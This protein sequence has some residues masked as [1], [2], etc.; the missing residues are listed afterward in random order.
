MVDKKWSEE[1]AVLI[2][3]NPREAHPERVELRDLLEE[4]AMEYDPHLLRLWLEQQEQ[5]ERDQAVPEKR[6]QKTN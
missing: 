3:E 1:S 5:A 4:L 6:K 2:D